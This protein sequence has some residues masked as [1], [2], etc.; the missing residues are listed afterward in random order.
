MW[1]VG[2]WSACVCV[3]CVGLCVVCGCGSGYVFM[4]LYMSLCVSM[5]DCGGSC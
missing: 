4:F 3:E 1:C 2:K 5:N